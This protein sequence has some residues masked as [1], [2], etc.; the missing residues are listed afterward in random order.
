MRVLQRHADFSAAILKREDLRHLRQRR[1][2]RGAVRPRLD[3]GANAAHGQILEA[4]LRVRSKAH[5]L[6]AGLRQAR[7]Q[8][9]A[10]DVVLVVLHPH[11][12][13]GKRFSKT[14]TS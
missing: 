14:T 6:A 5:D 8:A 1:Q 13:G 9:H 11:R 12:K 10:V 7:D 2:R 4:Q 3:D